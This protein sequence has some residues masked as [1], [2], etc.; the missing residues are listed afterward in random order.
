[1]SDTRSPAQ[2]WYDSVIK[3]ISG[4]GFPDSP[5]Y[6]LRRDLEGGVISSPIIEVSAGGKFL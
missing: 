4:L 2:E 5:A 3:A 6:A 1:M